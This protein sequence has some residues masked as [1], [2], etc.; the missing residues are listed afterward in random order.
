MTIVGASLGDPSYLIVV[1][2]NSKRVEWRE[3]SLPPLKGPFNETPRGITAV[4][5]NL[6]LM[7]KDGIYH[8]DRS[9]YGTK[10]LSIDHPVVGGSDQ[11]V[12]AGGKLYT[13]SDSNLLQ[14]DPETAKNRIVVQGSCNASTL[15]KSDGRYIAFATVNDSIGVY[16]SASATW[17]SFETEM[18]YKE[19]LDGLRPPYPF[20]FSGFIDGVLLLSQDNNPAVI[21]IGSDA[22]RR[23]Y[24][25]LMDYV[26]KKGFPEYLV[27]IGH[28]PWIIETYMVPS[29]GAGFRNLYNNDEFHVKHNI[30]QI[31]NLKV[32]AS[33]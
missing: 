21:A 25:R 31:V 26:Q 18:T 10:K 9:T 3:R 23:L 13:V 19:P 30:R 27:E 6:F 33:D 20:G 4:G 5:S 22:D 17:Q 2:V 11:L 32:Q 8:V 24:N 1:S 16:D 12:S 29:V 15:L 7:F 28:M 14:I